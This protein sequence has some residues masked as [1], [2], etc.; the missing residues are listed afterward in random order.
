MPQNAV[1]PQVNYP[2]ASIFKRLAA[3]LYDFLLILALWLIF[4]IVIVA[5]FVDMPEVGGEFQKP[6]PP[7][8]AASSWFSITF[9]F[10][11]YFWRR[12]GQT[13]GMQAWRIKLV[14]EQPGPISILQCMLR[15]GIGF[16]SV[17]SCGLGFLWMLWDKSEKTWH[18]RASMSKVVILPKDLK[19]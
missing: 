19:K 2:T 7:S 11:T 16:F 18:D 4:G 6:F 8:I 5:L 12:N 1:N 10:Y 3:M 15:V 14:S 9:L 13:L 17:L